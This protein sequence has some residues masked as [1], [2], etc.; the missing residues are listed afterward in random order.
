[1]FP[2][3]FNGTLRMNMPIMGFR[4]INIDKRC[5]NLSYH[6]TNFIYIHFDFA[7][8]YYPWNYDLQAM[9]F[10]FLL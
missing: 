7:S 4:S 3:I 10:T 9:Y 2:A 1:M 8:K 6:K 5:K